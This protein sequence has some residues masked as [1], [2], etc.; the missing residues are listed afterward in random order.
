MFFN[1]FFYFF[2]PLDKSAYSGEVE[3]SM[4]RKRRHGEQQCLTACHIINCIVNLF[5]IDF[6]HHV[7]VHVLITHIFI[8]HTKLSMQL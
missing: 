5:I 3:L 2:Y 1:E 4:S 7:I 8:M 6:L